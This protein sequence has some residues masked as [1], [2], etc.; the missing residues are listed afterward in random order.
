MRKTDTVLNVILSTAGIIFV[1]SG[2]ASFVDVQKSLGS[3][4]VIV[5]TNTEASELTAI[6]GGLF[7]VMGALCLFVRDRQRDRELTDFVGFSFIALAAAR[8][9]A[10]FRYGLPESPRIYVEFG[11]EL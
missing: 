11:W 4:G 6:Y 3:L 8:G 9:Y 2:F 7:M 10:A 1:V 5:L